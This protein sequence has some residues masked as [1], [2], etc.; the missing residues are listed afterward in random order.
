MCYGLK[1]KMTLAAR[2]RFCHHD[3]MRFILILLAGP[4]QTTAAEALMEHLCPSGD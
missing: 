3:C 4:D 1:R 2:F